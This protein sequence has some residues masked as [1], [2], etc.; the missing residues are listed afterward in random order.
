MLTIDEIKSHIIPVLKSYP[1]YKAILFGSYAR[2]DAKETSDVD[3]VVESKGRLFNR[4]IF[5][6]S[7]DLL[8]ALPVRVDVYDILEI[9]E[10]YDIYSRVQ[11]EGVV[12][13]ETTG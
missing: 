4:K 13:Y 11:N 2:G 1:V 9:M 8:S 6:L 12:I 7:G 10:M 3:L 5:A